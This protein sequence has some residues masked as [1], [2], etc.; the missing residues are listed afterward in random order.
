MYS[1]VFVA[2]TG[3][4]VAWLAFS[5][6]FVAPLFV[7]VALNWNLCGTL[8]REMFVQ[9]VAGCGFFFVFFC[10]SSSGVD[11][12]TN[13]RT[14]ALQGKASKNICKTVCCLPC[15]WFLGCH[16]AHF[17]LWFP[18]FRPP[19]FRPANLSLPE[20]YDTKAPLDN[21]RSTQL[22]STL[23]CLD[24]LWSKSQIFHAKRTHFTFGFCNKF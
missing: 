18:P 12:P 2:V 16:L 8:P 24:R 20:N 7:Y 6:Q 14:A 4:A 9:L 10:R 15:K 21:G 22:Q 17:G 1:A 19:I 23:L 11:R 3:I 5:L 13:C